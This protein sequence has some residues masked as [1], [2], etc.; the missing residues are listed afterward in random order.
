M[1]LTSPFL[2]LCTDLTTSSLRPGGTV[3]PVRRV[4]LLPLIVNLADITTTSSRLALS[5]VA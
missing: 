5:L 1:K 4:S 2:Y 3:Q